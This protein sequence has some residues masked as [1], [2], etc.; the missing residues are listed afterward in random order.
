MKQQSEDALQPQQDT[1]QA[2][3]DWWLSQFGDDPRQY[4]ARLDNSIRGIT[5][6]RAL[7]QMPSRA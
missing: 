3:R 7:G 6:I 5:P 1:A 2:Y 4:E